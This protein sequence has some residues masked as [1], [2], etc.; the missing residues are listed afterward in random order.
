MYNFN[1]RSLFT[2]LTICFAG[3]FI[4]ACEE[5]S[6]G[7]E[8]E[9]QIELYTA[10]DVPANPGGETG[11]PDDF[12]FFSLANNEIVA[13]A[14]SASNQWDIAFS[15]TNIIVNGG[16]SGPGE[17]GAVMLDAAFESVTTAP[18][19]GYQVDTEGSAAISGWY[20]YT[21]TT[22]P[23]HA[24]IPL[25]NK[26]IVVRT[27]NGEHYAK[28]KILSYYEGNPDTSTEEFANLQTRPADRYYTFE[29]AIQLDGSTELN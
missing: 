13:D 7:P 28:I 15:S 10:T 6:S 26:T 25:D 1:K 24:I 17:A 23:Q 22:E 29:Y 18:S 8:L 12:T 5:S 20:N 9:S 27:G 2:I 16:V 14:D 19:Q 3:F 21:G 4:T 11:G